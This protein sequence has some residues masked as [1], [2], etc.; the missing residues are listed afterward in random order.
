MKILIADDDR[1]LNHLL[2]SRLKA[3]GCE[4]VNAFDAMQA[5][6]SAVR[7]SP[8]A[9]VL[10]IHMPGG[11]GIEALKKLKANSKTAMIPVVV[12]SGSMDPNAAA[13]LVCD[14]GA[15]DFIPKP[16]DPEA[17]YAAI[18]RALEMTPIGV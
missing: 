13:A 18:A 14:L 10:D 8:D 11:T 5:L 12:L 17:V 15:A 7:A 1:V 2:T 9:I 4:V 16:A 3:K 6:M